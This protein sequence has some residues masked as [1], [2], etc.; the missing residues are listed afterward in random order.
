MRPRSPELIF[1]PKIVSPHL[2]LIPRF[3]LDLDGRYAISRACY[4]YPKDI[5][6]EKDLL[7]YL[8]AVLN[9]PI[10]HW[11]VS[12]HS[13]RYR[14]SYTMLE[15]KTLKTVPVP[16]PAN[17]SSSLVERLLSLVKRR[18]RDSAATSLESEIDNIVAEL[19]CLTSEDQQAIGIR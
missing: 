1:R 14:H 3:S 10:C 17:V 4:I 7:L 15:P 12:T 13:H 18:L 11:Y 8:V 2:V 16:N 5:E 6:V 9:S 19:Y